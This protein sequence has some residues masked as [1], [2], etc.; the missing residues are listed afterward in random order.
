MAFRAR[1]FAALPEAL[2]LSSARTEGGGQALAP[3][4][5]CRFLLITNN[6]K[7]N[8]E[9]FY[10]KKVYKP[11]CLSIRKR[12]KIALFR[13]RFL[14]EKNAYY[15]S[16]F[17]IILFFS[18]IISNFIWGDWNF[19]V[20]GRFDE[21]KIGQFGDFVGGVIGSLFA[22]VGVILYYV[23]L[24]EQ[25]KDLR[26]NQN[27]LGL[28]TKALNQQV[29]EFKA[30]EKELKETREV[31]EK[32]TKLFEKQ[33][34]FYEAQAKE[35]KKQTDILTLQ[36][37][38]S[39]F[40]SLVKLLH[41]QRNNFFSKD[42]GPFG[43]FINRTDS[44]DRKTIIQKINE[45]NQS[46]ETNVVQGNEYLDNY[47]QVF[48]RI[49]N[50]LNEADIDIKKRAHYLKVLSSQ[51]TKKEKILLFYYTRTEASVNDKI[52]MA[53]YKE[54]CKIDTLDKL[55]CIYIDD[56]FTRN[57]LTYLYSQIEK[58][59]NEAFDTFTA[60]DYAETTLVKIE[61][62][63]NKAGKIDFKLELTETNLTASLLYGQYANS[64]DDEILVQTTEFLFYD[65]FFLSK[66]RQPTENAFHSTIEHQSNLK[67]VTIT[68]NIWESIR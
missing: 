7:E 60:L 47:T 30:Q 25:R 50:L 17:G 46:F 9:Y 38:E 15:L 19:S 12:R 10:R 24:K 28:Q 18:F 33:T 11:M 44:I 54:L 45:V 57:L 67:K 2:G 49:L 21:E 53:R 3:R 14:S 6:N 59:T 36:Q 13:K 66:H 40:L 31:Y 68:S 43:L 34:Q 56:F 48:F 41:D 16:I 52:L 64:I 42:S 5:K 63:S 35:Y 39:S 51:L 37:F 65:I 55:E 61:T 32:Q 26:M 8:K 4:K 1:P 20:F 58:I 22:L 27:S 23:A 29:E 62:I